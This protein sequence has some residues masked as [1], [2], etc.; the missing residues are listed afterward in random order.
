MVV[1]KVKYSQRDGNFYGKVQDCD[2]HEENVEE[3]QDFEIIDLNH[4]LEGDCELKFLNFESP[5][6]QQTFWHSSSHVLGYS[7]E[8]NYDGFLT[9]G[10]PLEEG[11]FYDCW[12]GKKHIKPEDYKKIEK[13]AKYLIKKNQKFERVLLTKGQALVLFQK[14]SFK[15][16]LIQSKVSDKGYTTAYKCGELID[17]CLGP[18]LPST[19]K[20][21]GF[22]VMNNSSSYWLHKNTNDVL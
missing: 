3:S 16:K 17:L 22:K 10:P 20:I 5:E 9:H 12:V 4:F 8:Q 13:S 7:L 2:E 19:G 11:F 14:S 21:K 18:H 1:A 15:V 6:G